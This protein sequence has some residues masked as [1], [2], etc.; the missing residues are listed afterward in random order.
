MSAGAPRVRWSA[1]VR[2]ILR[3][4]RASR[5]RL[6]FFT[7]CLAIGVA[8]VV[9]VS[10]LVGA[11]DAGVRAESKSLLAADLAV[12]A[13]RPLPQEI[14]SFFEGG[15]FEGSAHERTDVTELAAMASV[16]EGEELASRLVELQ[17]VAGRYPFYGELVTD[18]PGLDVGALGSD[19]ALVGPEL[20]LALDL[21]PGS[22]L[23]L[24]GATFRV[25]GR[26]LSQPDKLDFAMTLG[27]RV[28]V[29]GAGFQ[30]TALGDARN[31]V[32]YRAL[33]WLEGVEEGGALDRTAE[34]LDA[35]LGD[36]AYLRVRTHDEAQPGLQRSLGRLEEYLG[37]VALLSL[38]LGGIGVSQIVRAWLAGRAQS[39]AVMRC[40]GL[41]AREVAGLYLGHVGLL[42][43]LGCLV[44]GAAGVAIPFLVQ[45]RAPEL[46][47]GGPEHLWQPLALVRGIGLGLLVAL[48]FSLPP[49]TAIW[50]VPP[51][52]VLR[53][54]AVPLG[55]PRPVRFG[56]PLAL[57]MGVLVVARV[58]GGA[59]IPALLF[60]G[61]LLVLAALLWGGAR[62]ATRAA[63]R[64]PRGKLGPYLEH[65]LSSLARPG[66]GTTG[67]IVAL[68][69]G[70]LV[71]VAMVLI[72]DRLDHAL[73]AALPTDAPSVFLVDVQ[74]EQWPDVERTLEDAGSSSVDMVPVVMARLTGIDGVGT[75]EL[76]HER[77][78]SDRATWVFTREQ[79]LTWLEELPEDNVVIE[80]LDEG[81]LWSDPSRAEVSIEEDFAADLGV[82]VGSML[83]LDVQGVEVELLVSSIRT[84]DWQGFGINFFLVVEP[85]VLEEA[86][87][88]RMAAARL[89]PPDA[90]LALQN[91]LARSHPNV[92]VLRIRPILERIA[93]VL[94]RIALAV[95]AL[96]SF[97]I[98]TGIVILAG[99]VGST[100]LRRAREA[101]L[102]KTLGVTR[103]GVT[104][105]FAVEYALGGLVAGTIG[106]AGA[107]LLAWAFLEHLAELDVELPW[108][109]IPVGA[110]ATA[111]L[112][113]L[114]GLSASLR[115]LTARPLHSLRG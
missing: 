29:T 77:S 105:L 9:G 27:P 30:R 50:R 68:G 4:S 31:R 91:E 60:S 40:L 5:G 44:G 88:F 79:R 38:L 11:V 18:P 92:T 107:L 82:G 12:S 48:L 108:L 21:E 57:L 15:G 37:L 58:Q 62:L 99:S 10:A 98:L 16:G 3:E 86:P 94:G 103:G 65:G 2:A 36:P 7:G 106:S 14:D 63:A 74:P 109:A 8:A 49:L 112:A 33:F 76:A 115:A 111:L 73:R 45:T 71:V 52:A 54:E 28:V 26:V 53:S 25:A 35:H 70:V 72:E 75:L 6:L 20:A 80:A 39:V 56:A 61:G 43:I 51:A 90:E 41:R 81:V 102:L 78:E 110:L 113:T 64:V 101:A 85:G 100:A 104:R 23:E 1:I 83:A 96:G 84:V 97:T 55:V 67:A 89:E 24:G 42:A 66:A 22:E 32:K 87:H 114:S 13:R 59:W 93:D 46:F 34:A 69:L 47:Q 95:R 19:E 17:S